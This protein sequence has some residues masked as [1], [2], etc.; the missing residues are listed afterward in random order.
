MDRRREGEYGP[1]REALGG[2]LLRLRPGGDVR[3]NPISRLAGAEQQDALLQ[4]VAAAALG[5]HLRPEEATG[6]TAALDVVRSKSDEPTLPEVVK[7]LL[8]PTADM[9]TRLVTSEEKL[10]VDV[11]SA[12]LGLMRLCEGELRGMFDGPTSAS[13]DWN[14]KNIVIDLSEVANSRALA[15]L[16]ACA[17]AE[18]QAQVANRHRQAVLEQRPTPKTHAIIDECWRVYKEVMLGE[19]LQAKQKLA[20]QF[21]EAVWTIM[22]RLSDLTAAGDAG[23]KE[24]QLAEGLL[25]DTDI[26][27]SYKQASDQIRNH[28]ERL[29][30]T[31]TQA[32]LLPTFMPGVALHQIGTH[33]AVVQHRLSSIER[34]IIETDQNMHLKAA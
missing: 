7:V 2:S 17:S 1:L 3:L 13:I 20:R 29:A 6:V 25:S 9:A 18:M 19:L 23:S 12:A 11:R 32:G 31:S 14:A 30:L 24:V 21:G 34:R 16:M 26:R 15:V 27:I 8:V 33:S 28:R 22:H 4:A 10:A 5:R